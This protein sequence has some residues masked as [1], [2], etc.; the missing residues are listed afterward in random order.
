MCGIGIS[1]DIDYCQ[2]CTKRIKRRKRDEAANVLQTTAAVVLFVNGGWT[3]FRFFYLVT[4]GSALMAWLAVIVNVVPGVLLLLKRHPTILLAQFFII[5]GGVMLVMAYLVENCLVCI[6]AQLLFTVSLSIMV[7]GIKTV[8]CHILLALYLLMTAAGFQGTFTGKQLFGGKG[9]IYLF[10]K[11]P[12][13][14]RGKISVGGG[15]TLKIPSKGWKPE[16]EEDEGKEG[17]KEI[18]QLTNRENGAKV[19]IFRTTNDGEGP[20]DAVAFSEEILADANMGYD[21]FRVIWRDTIM[22]EKGLIGNTVLAEGVVQSMKMYLF[23]SFFIDEN[24]FYSISCSVEQ[25]KYYKVKKDFRDII[26]SFE[27]SFEGIK[28]KGTQ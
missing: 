6:M 21:Q 23:Y 2:K 14:V 7:S 5:A 12:G 28:M 18:L 11:R 20:P 8:A 19:S 22:T 16:K 9:L 25:E 3:F 15:S 10:G 27:P 13:K 24:S 17:E 26:S 1:D 4:G